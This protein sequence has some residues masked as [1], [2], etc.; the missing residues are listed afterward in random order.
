[1]RSPQKVFNYFLKKKLN[2]LKY[3][4]TRLKTR[5]FHILRAFTAHIRGYPATLHKTYFLLQFFLIY[6]TNIF[7]RCYKYFLAFRKNIFE[8]GIKFYEL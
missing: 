7:E 6:V 3:E 2:A 5:L 4:K 1:M 8:K